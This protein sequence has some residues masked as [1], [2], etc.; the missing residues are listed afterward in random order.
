MTARAAK[1]WGGRFASGT[2]EIA[3]K[4]SESVSF[5][6]RLYR[7]DVRGSI[8]HAKMLGETGI[9]S[10][11]D[12]A[13]IAKALREIEKEIDRGEFPFSEEYEDIHLNIEK[14]LIEKTG[15]AGAR[16]HTARSRN[17]QVLADTRLY[18]KKEIGEIVSLALELAAEFVSSAE[19]NMGTV[20]PLYTHMQRAQP[21]LL[22]HH[23]LAY[24][25]MLVRDRR[26]FMDCLGRVDASPL[27]CCAGRERPFR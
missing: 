1:A 20:L 15:D 17:D 23:L 5:D 12:S 4:F 6:R 18:L 10:K 9:I 21:V 22:S 26:R 27:G 14:R 2:R 24:Y 16:V 8:A 13:R 7:E 11:K 19:R 25:E 3:E